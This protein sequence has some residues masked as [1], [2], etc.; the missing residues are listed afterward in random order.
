SLQP[1]RCKRPPAMKMAQQYA[2]HPLHALVFFAWVLAVQLTGLAAFTKGFFLT[3][4]ELGR[5]SQ[6]DVQSLLSPDELQHLSG[7]ATRQQQQQQ[8]QGGTPSSDPRHP[9]ELSMPS[10]LPLDG[11]WLPPRFKRVVWVVVDALRYDFA[12]FSPAGGAEGGADGKPHSAGARHYLNH[13]PVINEA[14]GG[15]GGGGHVGGDEATSR[16]SAFEGSGGMLFQFEADPPTVTMQ[17]LK[18]LTTGGLP[19]FIDFRDNFH[20]PEIAEDN[21]VSQVRDR[22]AGRRRRGR[23]KHPAGADGAP[24]AAGG[25]GAGGNG[26]GG[27]VFMGDDTWTSLYPTYFSR[28]YPFPSFNTRDLHTVDDGVLAHLSTE[29]AR[30]DWDVLVAHFLGV[31][32]VGHTFGP[33]SQAMEDKLD[34]MDAALRTVF[35]GVHDDTVVFV[36]G[37]HGM[38]EDGNHGGA[39]PEETGAALLVWSPSGERLLGPGFLRP[40]GGNGGDDGGKSEKKFEHEN[41]VGRGGEGGGSADRR[42]GGG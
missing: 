22:A 21:W 11:C 19:T 40:S 16:A 23:Q 38:T 15:G 32:H 2:P 36:L 1:Y 8:Q 27:V 31:D 14:I 28:S 9:H 33:G 34:Q 41:E 5:Q 29:L 37:D 3:R 42:Q 26:D 13:L 35:E 6:C 17:R 30:R 39:T 24:A 7:V 25:E 4:V 12:A 18:G 20:S 10:P